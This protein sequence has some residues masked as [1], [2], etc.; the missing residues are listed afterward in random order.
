MRDS[1]TELGEDCRDDGGKET[2]ESVPAKALCA[3]GSSGQDEG[4]AAGGQMSRRLGVLAQGEGRWS[5]AQHSPE[6]VPHVGLVGC[7]NEHCRARN[8][9]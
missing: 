7:C 4:R 3:Q 1:S 9:A 2:A 6:D 8:H 5:L